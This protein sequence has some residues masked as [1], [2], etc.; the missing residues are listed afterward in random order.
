MTFNVPKTLKKDFD[1]FLKVNLTN[2]VVET[3]I[4]HDWAQRSGQNYVTIKERCEWYPD[5]TKSRYE[6]TDN[7]LNVRFSLDSV[8]HKGDIVLHPNGDIFLLDWDMPP[9]CNNKA[10]RALRC[11][12]LL[13]VKRWVPDTVD[14]NGMLAVAGHYADVVTNLP[15][16]AYHY[17]GRPE[18]SAINGTPG[19]VPN[20]ITI[21]TVQYNN[22]TKNL[23][24]DDVFNW[25]P[26]EIQIIDI[27]YVG[28]D[29]VHNDNIGTL[30]IQ[31][32]KTAGGTNYT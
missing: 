26:D 22:Q 17:D 11:N 18:Y 14:E 23:R 5:S 3:E 27:S 12:F 28:I 31:G 10:S 21:M 2:Q 4:V 24:I 20:G 30:K 25:G 13:N 8:A 1:D 19:V 6:N 32:K 16:N 15:T 29:L 7:N 9:E